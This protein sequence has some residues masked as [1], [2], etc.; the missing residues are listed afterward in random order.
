[1]GKIKLFFDMDGTIVKMNQPINGVEDLFSDGF[2]SRLKPY[3]NLLQ[4]VKILIK[5]YSKKYSVHILTY[6]CGEE[7]K[8]EK[9]QWL[10]QYLPEVQFENRY[11]LDKGEDKVKNFNNFNWSYVLVDDNFKNYM[12][13]KESGGTSIY[14]MNGLNTREDD[15]ITEMISYDSTPKMIADEINYQVVHSI[16]KRFAEGR[17][18]E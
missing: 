8:K 4:A 11:F 12:K 7:D 6:V 14:C 18:E 3:E 15:E 2:F 10:D 9:N 13:W 17:I 1:M 16:M 5:D